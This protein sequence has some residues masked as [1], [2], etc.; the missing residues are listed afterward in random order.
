MHGDFAK[1]AA[2][3]VLGMLRD[4]G[5]AAGLVV[6]LGCGTG[7]WARELIRA[8]YSVLG[9]RHFAGHDS[10]GPQADTR[11]G[12]PAGIVSEGQSARVRCCHRDRGVFQLPFRQNEQ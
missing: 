1:T 6:D 9:C 7:I 3:G 12:I 10:P 2:S 5:I 8:G 11:G 4:K